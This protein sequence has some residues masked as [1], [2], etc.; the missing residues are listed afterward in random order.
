MEA[1]L[2]GYDLYEFVNGSNPAPPSHTTK[3]EISTPNP[4]YTNWF[5]QNKLLFGV[6]ART[7][8]PSLSPFITRATTFK[9]VWDIMATTYVC[10]SRGHLKQLKYQ[11]KHISKG[12]Y[13][14]SEFIQHMKRITEELSLLGDPIKREDITYYILDG[15][16]SSYQSVIDTVHARDQSISFEALHEKLIN[17]QLALKQHENSTIH[18]FPASAYPTHSCTCETLVH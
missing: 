6:I 10:P 14:I 11:L 3:I 9:E 1:L 17:K 2:I 13:S 18:N 12:T 4:D 7:R 8:S 5:R 15:L 16:D